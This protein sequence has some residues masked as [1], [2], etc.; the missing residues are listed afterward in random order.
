[1]VRRRRWVLA[2]WAVLLLACAAAY[3]FLQAHLRAPDYGV[4]GA[5]S[6][7]ARHL[8]DR[9]FGALGGEQDMIVFRSRDHVVTDAEYRAVVGRTVRAARRVPGIAS[10]IRPSGHGSA[11]RISRDRRVAVAVVGLRG[12]AGAR[13]AHAEDLQAAVRRA[14]G[15]DVRAYLTGYSPIA[16]D[17]GAVEEADAGRAESIGIPVAFVVLLFALGALVAALVPLAAAGAGLLLA[18]GML[19]AICVPLHVDAFMTTIVAMIGTGLGIDYS[20]FVVSRFREELTRRSDTAEAVGAAI[21]TSGRTV[22]FSGVIVV[23]ALCSLFVVDAPIFREIA[24]GVLVVVACTLAVA[25]TL[26]PALLGVLGA[27][28]NAGALPA[29]LRPADTRTGRAEGGWARWARTVMRRPVVCG[30]LAGGVLV[31]AALPVGGM[32]YGID[33]GTSSLRATPAGMGQQAL[34]RSFGPGLLAPTRVVVTGRADRPLDA[35]GRARAASLARRLRADTRVTA[36]AARS[37]GGRV[38]LDVVPSVAIDSSA[39][40][41]LVRDIRDDAAARAGGPDRSQVLVGGTTAQFVDLSAETSAK[42]PVVLVLVLGASLLLLLPVFRSAVLP[43]KAVAMNLLATAAAL[44]CAVA[45]FQLGH[46]ADLLGFTSTGFLQVYVPMTVFALLFGMSMDYEVFLIGRMAEE[47]RAGRGDTAAVAAGIAHTA[48]PIS[49]AAAIMVVVFGSFVTADV[50]ELKEFGFALAVA[51]ALDAT[52]V[53]LV[54]VPAFMRLLGA[55]NW[56]LPRWL[57]R[58]LPGLWS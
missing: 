41:R 49:A 20:L 48:R 1:M 30:L 14:A 38:L 43:V 58:R 28:V 37:A 42:F 11:D 3:P 55:R 29:R 13:A 22:I 54:L 4:G 27:R 7:R 53:R 12:D 50:L 32:R 5:E 56:W 25:L 9:H 40:T 24:L 45:V 34:T 15:P 26:L 6:T 44:G 2:V 39:A 16:N 46:G 36:V 18:F 23:I 17:L 52:L 19:A 57:D 8:V 21:A 51:V 33:L 10:V 31:L 35:A 47:R